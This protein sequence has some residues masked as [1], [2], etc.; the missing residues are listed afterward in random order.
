MSVR[1]AFVLIA[2]SLGATA[3]S[4]ARYAGRPLAEA[5]RDL[6][7]RGLRLIYSDD[8]VLPSM[9]VKQEPRSAEPRAILDE[10]L[11]EH[12]LR[13]KGGPRGSLLIVRDEA[14]P[15]A[16]E[17]A[18]PAPPMP[19]ALAQIVVTPSR[20]EIL[21]SQPEQRQFLGR[22][23]VRAIPHLSDDL[24]RAVGRIPGT[25]A[26][27]TTARFNIRGGASN[28]VLA[29]VDGAEIYDP[30]HLKDLFR[31]FST[32]DAE[33]VGSVEV[34]TGGFPAEY[35][36]RMSGVI[37]ISTLSPDARQTEVGI[38]LLNTRAMSAGTFDGGRGQW[39]V[40]FR[41]G[42][43][44]EM[45]KLI[46]VNN[47]LD[48]HYYDLLGKVQWTVG[49]SAVASFHVLAS[50]DLMKTVNA[51]DS[52]ARAKYDDTYF[53]VNLRGT[54]APRIFAQSVLSYATFGRSRSG[55]F[56]VDDTEKGELSDHRSASFVALKN[57]ASFDL[58]PRNVV[59]G[60]LT[61]RRLRARY[62][63][64]SSS[65]INFAPFH[66][67]LPPS[68]TQ[69]SERVRAS[70]SEVAAYAADRM[71]LG[72]GVIAELGLRVESETHTPDGAHLSPRV[73]VSWFAGGRTVLR[74]A[75]GR[76]QQPEAIYEL[77]VEDGVTKFEA[78]EQ[79]EHRVLGLEQRFGRAV[80]VRA[81]LYGKSFSHLRPR[82]ENLYDGLVIFPELHADRVRIAPERGSARGAEVLAR[83]DGGGTMSG[84]ISYGRAR[85]TDRLDG[86]DVPRAWDQRDSASFSVNCRRERWNFNVAGT[87]HTGWP[88][89]PIVARLQNGRI[90]SE[91]GQLNSERLPTYRRVD[92]R[93]SRS[94]GSLGLFLELFNVL[95]HKNA[96]RVESFT[97]D[98]QPDGEVRTTP[99]FQSI[100]GIVPSF[101]VTWRF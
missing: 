71:H 6:Q 10:L 5:L 92:F 12:R 52:N 54:P 35:G 80:S 81:E 99:N 83:Y 32:I 28:E 25:T 19:V 7:T 23:E 82:F 62:D 91:L 90:V 85:A 17:E 65:S 61:L 96:H 49:P 93:V 95:D 56:T 68:Q 86:V 51:F 4:A 14:R 64:S 3:A 31:A 48:P 67:G 2:L 94:S 20:F 24:F 101:G 74:A 79:S 97:F 87:W 84:W 55:S 38:S 26:H 76:F 22:E 30:Y 37:D 50:R 46:A 9:I 77:P 18:K 53:W 73:N 36:G 40:S 66:L 75:W 11:R 63:Y 59:K 16:T 72:R 47:E 34:L 15:A 69:R 8:V 60:G 41:R 29:I 100:F 33:A 39:L 57:D 98:V 43:L 42:Y 88:T 70:S 89:T 1:L 45:L 78:A 21:S 13:A 44:R 58:S 27:D